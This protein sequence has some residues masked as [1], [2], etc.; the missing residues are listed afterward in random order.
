MHRQFSQPSASV[1]LA[2]P[3]VSWA[4]LVQASFECE[5]RPRGHVPRNGPAVLVACRV[6]RTRLSRALAFAGVRAAGACSPRRRALLT[7]WPPS[8]SLPE[9]LARPRLL[10]R[11][12]TP[13]PCALSTV[14]L[15]STQ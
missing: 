1:P 5:P 12:E 11:P 2:G 9:S 7:P 15:Q 13:S 14:P 4:V 10:S 6:C 3:K 8:L